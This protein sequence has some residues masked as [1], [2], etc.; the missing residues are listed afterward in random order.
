MAQWQLNPTD[1]E[2]IVVLLYVDVK[3]GI[4]HECGRTFRSVSLK[5]ILADFVLIHADEFDV[6]SISEGGKQFAF[7]PE[8]KVPA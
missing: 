1:N 3:H 7:L 8:H 4:L 6:I 5:E 2:A